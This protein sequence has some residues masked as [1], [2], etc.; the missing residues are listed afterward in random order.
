[1][2]SSVELEQGE[3]SCALKLI[4]EDFDGLNKTMVLI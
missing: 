1:L 3:F 2:K 4:A